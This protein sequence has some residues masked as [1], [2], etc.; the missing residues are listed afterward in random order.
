MD[1]TFTLDGADV[2]S[3]NLSA[4]HQFFGVIDTSGFTNVSLSTS[5]APNGDWGA[6]DFTFAT[7]AVSV[8]EPPIILLLGSGL[9]G[10]IGLYRRKVCA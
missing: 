2:F 4:Q 10:F 5:T 9:I 3:V 7:S 1:F 6:D 8:P